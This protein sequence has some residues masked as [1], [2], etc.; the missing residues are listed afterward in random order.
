M[1]NS[2]RQTGKKGKGKNRWKGSYKGRG[3]KNAAKRAGY[4]YEEETAKALTWL[5]L[6]HRLFYHKEA[7]THAL[8]STV[9][10]ILNMFYD[11]PIQIQ[12]QFQHVFWAFKKITLPKVPG[13]YWLL[14]QGI[15]GMWELK[16]KMSANTPLMLSHM[17]QQ[18]QF[19]YATK[20]EVYGG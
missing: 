11:L 20:I 4:D 2:K 13:D 8:R 19:Q 18:H 10:R 7:D 1:G 9:R 3:N 12:D 16:S 14:I 17:I 6:N 15:G 5:H